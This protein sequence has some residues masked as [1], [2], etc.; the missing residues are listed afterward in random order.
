MGLLYQSVAEDFFTG[1]ILHC[2]GWKSTYLTPSRAQFLGSAT[3]NM[4][5]LLT[6]G[7]RWSSGLIQVG[8]SRFCPLIYGPLRTSCLQSL[9]YA[10][11]SLFPIFY[12][13]P[14][15]CFATVPQLCLLNGISL[16]P[17]VTSPYFIIFSFIFL[18]AALKHLQEV[19]STGGTI[20]TWR[21]EQRM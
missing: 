17:E 19:V 9:C 6:Q 5:D 14:L 16:Y 20:E 4:N 2:K 13:L 18:S 10:D 8:L 7:V 3:T 15:W 12:C 21:N 11:L 1:F